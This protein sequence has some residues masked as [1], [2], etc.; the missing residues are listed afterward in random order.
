MVRSKPR[1]VEH[2]LVKGSFQ[3]V[4][5]VFSET[6][7]LVTN[8][9]SRVGQIRRCAASLSQTLTQVTAARHKHTLPD[10]TYDYG[11]LEPHVSAE[12]MQLHHS[13]HHATYVN[14]LNVT[15]EKYQEAL[16]KGDVTAQ[17]SLQPALRF[18]GGGHINHTI[19]WTNLSPNGGGEPQGELMEAINRDFGSFQKMKEKMSAATVAV[20]G[21][22]WGWLGF[23]KES[24]RL[25][26]AACAN[27]DPL[28]G[29]TGL[30]PLLGIDVWEHAYYLQ[31]KNVRPDYVKAMWNIINWE[32]VSERLQ[33]AKK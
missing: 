19:F 27:Q 12:I 23:E 1:Q 10:L 2:P 29:T 13:K 14:N 18:N 16:A 9:L 11:A 21:S 15:E 33:T 5:C 17:V 22:G 20:Q 6:V 4:V 25:R 26:I 8:M 31:Y 3:L 28:Q 30:I 24:G 7:G 32:N